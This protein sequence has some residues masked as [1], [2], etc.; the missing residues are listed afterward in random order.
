MRDANIPY[1]IG[2]PLFSN[3]TQL[4]LAGPWEVLT[5]VPNARC[6]LLAHDLTPVASANG[7]L[8]VVPNMTLADCP[9]LDVICVPGGPGHLAAMEDERLLAFLQK[10]AQ[11]CRYVTSVCTG[12]LVLAAAGLLDGYRATTHWMSLERLGAFGAVP[13][14]DRVVMDRSRITGGGV[15]AGTDFGL[16]LLA[17]IAGEQIARE[18]AL[19]IEYDPEP[20]YRGSPE[21]A[22][23]DAVNAMRA[24]AAGYFARMA[25][26]DALAL[27]RIKASQAPP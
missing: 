27:A 15:T 26:V 4:D 7:G 16:R 21:A 12:A 11:G 6:H 8:A 9:Q 5:R 18:C 23:A 2:F 14:A 1:H 19:Q 17:E 25:A 3:L 24:K 22:G 10:Q 13:V 20:P